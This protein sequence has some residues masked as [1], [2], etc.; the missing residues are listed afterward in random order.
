MSIVDDFVATPSVET[1]N[2]LTKIQLLDIAERYKVPLI[3]ED[4]RSKSLMQLVVKA[5]LIKAQVLPEEEATPPSPA[6]AAEVTYEQQKELLR[7]QMEKTRL[8]YDKE[9]EKRRLDREVELFKLDVERQRLALIERGKMPAGT[10]GEFD[11]A[12]S[13]KLV[14]KFDE[15]KVETFFTLFERVANAYHWPDVERT[16]LLQCTLTGRAQEAYSALD[17][18]ESL[19]Y[20]SVKQAVLKAYELVP[21]A[22]RQKFR[23]MRK[24]PTQTY[25]DFAREL[26]VQFNRWCVASG[27]ETQAGLT[28]LIL[29]EQ[30]KNTLPEAMATFLSE[31]EAITLTALAALA[32]DYALIHKSRFSAPPSRDIRWSR[33]TRTPRDAVPSNRGAP[34]A[35][36]Q[37]DPSSVCNYCLGKGHW[38]F[39]CPV[40]RGKEKFKIPV[41]DN[42]SAL[43]VGHL[44]CVDESF[45]PFVFDGYVS[46]RRGSDKIAVK[47]LRDTGSVESFICR[48]TLPFS[49]SSDTGQCVFVRGIN[50]N[51]LTVPLHSV[52]LESVLV[53]G[54]VSLGVRPMLPVRGVSVILGN[55]LAGAC[56]WANGVVECGGVQNSSSALSD[57]E[58]APVSVVTR[59]SS[60]RTAALE[61]DDAHSLTGL[62]T[63][64][65]R[66]Q[67]I[68]AQR[69]DASLQMLFPK[70]RGCDDDVSEGYI[71]KDEVL[72]RKRPS[73]GPADEHAWQV[74]VPTTL[75][76]LVLKTAHDDAG[77]MG[78]RKTYDQVTRYC[79]WPRV[80]RDITE[81]VRACHVCQQTGKPNQ[82][83][84]PVPLRPITP[85]SKPF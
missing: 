57:R 73:S 25:T 23:S 1:F 33:N 2:L 50:L 41:K 54:D 60:K 81:H 20:D 34:R 78:V 27:A 39:E 67:V 66:Q 65:S 46:L 63:S 58:V 74:V 48:S 26:A 35:R 62:P 31:R 5:A 19:K 55:G 61:N 47:I 71:L 76:S 11:V 16:L 53:S 69:S 80:K 84:K 13:L 42:A 38:K 72:M 14:P 43:P 44:A 49:T 8:E 28:N 36:N 51:V 6:A 30:L 83:P 40:L 37:P 22:Y 85:A 79:Y 64:I 21:E 82:M 15:A 56:V 9:I 68:D 10:P 24:R 77:H 4:K 29:V 45:S 75:R 52:Y 70:V 59:S 12:R 7:L 18:T 32:D 17:G 3:S